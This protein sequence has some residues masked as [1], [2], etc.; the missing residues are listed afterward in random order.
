MRCQYQE[1]WKLTS[2]EEKLTNDLVEVIVEL[3]EL[4]VCCKQPRKILPF[5]D[6]NIKSFCVVVFRRYNVSMFFAILFY[7]LIVFNK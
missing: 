1:N 3:G 5:T 2:H 7:V 6:S 4:G